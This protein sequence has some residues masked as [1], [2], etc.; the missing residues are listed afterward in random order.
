MRP[1]IDV[2][3]SFRHLSSFRQTTYSSQFF[4]PLINDNA[5][6]LA[7]R[8]SPGAVAGIGATFQ[9]GKLKISPEARYTRWANQAFQSSDGLFKTNLGQG[10]VLVGF[11]F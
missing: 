5:M 2:G 8:N 3:A 11:T 4:A 1:F 10:D 9:V 7:H 6:E